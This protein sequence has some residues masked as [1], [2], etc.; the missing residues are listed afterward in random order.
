ML[1]VLTVVGLGRNI[2]GTQS[3]HLNFFE[4]NMDTIC[5]CTKPCTCL[6]DKAVYLK[7]QQVKKYRE[8][9]K[10]SRTSKLRGDLIEKS[11]KKFFEKCAKKGW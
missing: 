7:D 4:V 8:G 3:R 5:N 10:R 9:L 6:S 2:T 11:M 1:S